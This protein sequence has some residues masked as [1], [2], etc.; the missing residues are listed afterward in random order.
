M[1]DHPGE[2]RPSLDDLLGIHDVE[3]VRDVSLRILVD[4]LEDLAFLARDPDDTAGVVAVTRMGDRP[5]R[6]QFE[7]ESR[8][9]IRVLLVRM[10]GDLYAFFESRRRQPRTGSAGL[11]IARLGDLR[12]PFD[13]N[14]EVIRKILEADRGP[15]LVCNFLRRPSRP[16][17]VGAIP[18]PPDE[19]LCAI[20][21]ADDL[22]LLEVGVES[23]AHPGSRSMMAMP[24]QSA[25]SCRPRERTTI[26]LARPQVAFRL[27][28]MVI[29]GDPDEWTIYG[30]RIGDRELLARGPI[31]GSALSPRVPSPS[32]WPSP[33]DVAGDPDPRR[34]AGHVG[35]VFGVVSPGLSLS[36]DVAYVGGDPGGAPFQAT[37]VGE[38]LE[39]QATVGRRFVARCTPEGGRPPWAAASE[40]EPSA[41]SCSIRS[42]S[43]R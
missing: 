35:F 32:T 18:L 40:I 2:G 39:G 21:E 34:F 25:A 15:P 9:S 1:I 12:W 37:L 24:I 23:Y 14:D 26:T 11:A 33:S 7:F 43:A 6:S 28:R 27:G 36:L 42:G 5:H 38:T 30:M 17:I 31:R 22:L 20:R 10:D 8:V 41:D 3:V 19:V 4:D 29:S 13:R 16:P